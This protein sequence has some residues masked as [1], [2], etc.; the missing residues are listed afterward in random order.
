LEYC[1]DSGGAMNFNVDFHYF[2]YLDEI[3][4]D[5]I[6]DPIK[7]SYQ[8]PNLPDELWNRHP[9]LTLLAII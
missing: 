9:D 6:P 5:Y 2:I 1:S 7:S 3:D 8:M 4:L